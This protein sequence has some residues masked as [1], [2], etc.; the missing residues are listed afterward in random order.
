MLVSE[1]PEKPTDLKAVMVNSRSVNL[2]W[3]HQTGDPTD[4]TKYIVQFKEAS[5]NK[6]SITLINNNIA[7]TQLLSIVTIKF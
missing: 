5:G 3:A 7:K 1:P 4:V 2:Q 6:T